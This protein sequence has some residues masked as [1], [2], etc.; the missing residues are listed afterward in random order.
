MA[1]RSAALSNSDVVWSSFSANSQ[2]STSFSREETSSTEHFLL[3]TLQTLSSR[4]RA[5]E[6]PVDDSN[7]SVRRASTSLLSVW[8]ASTVGKRRGVLQP[9]VVKSIRMMRICSRANFS[10]QN[11]HAGSRG[12][13]VLSMMAVQQL[14]HST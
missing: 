8:L 9:L 3:A 7:R 12:G 4:R 13:A 10:L 11:G 2:S 6:L 14:V 1:R 5:R